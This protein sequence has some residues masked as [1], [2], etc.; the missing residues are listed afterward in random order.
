MRCGDDRPSSRSPAAR[1]QR[2]RHRHQDADEVR[3]AERAVDA[4][5]DAGAV[6]G[7]LP[8]GQHEGVGAG[9]LRQRHAG[10]RRGARRPVRRAA[11]RAASLLRVRAGRRAAPPGRAPAPPATA[12]EPPGQ[13]R[14]TPSI[15]VG[16]QRSARMPT[17]APDRSGR[18]AIVADD[19]PDQLR[20]REGTLETGPHGQRQQRQAR[21]SEQRTHR[22]ILHRSSHVRL[23][24]DL[25]E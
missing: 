1:G 17:R 15:H 9:P 5:P 13:R 18:S 24:A 19:Q 14:R 20:Q 12:A 7:R 11:S 10:A 21:G 25:Q 4:H 2:Q 8:P 6:D 22:C 23:T 16:R 3:V